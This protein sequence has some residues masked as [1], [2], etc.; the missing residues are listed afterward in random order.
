MCRVYRYNIIMREYSGTFS[1]DSQGNV[2]A[3]VIKH[4]CRKFGIA[5]EIYEKS[6]PL[7]L[8]VAYRLKSGPH[9][10]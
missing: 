3:G 2:K 10:F 7:C 4:Y 8:D 1:T 6:N 5:V 9:S